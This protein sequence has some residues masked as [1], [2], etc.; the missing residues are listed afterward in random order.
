MDRSGNR[1]RH[2]IPRACRGYG[3]PSVQPLDIR[4]YYDECSQ[5]FD[6]DSLFFSCNSYAS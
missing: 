1:M 2:G 4:S 6:T 3:F 5:V